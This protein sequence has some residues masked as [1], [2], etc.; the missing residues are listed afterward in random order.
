ME[1][2]QLRIFL[3]AA[4]KNSFSGAARSLYI[5]HSSVSRAIAALEAELGSTLIQRDGNV[6]IGLTDAGRVLKERAPLL[7]RMAE[8]AEEAV[9]RAG[10]G[11]KSE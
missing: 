8:E 9:R 10:N 4:D 5:S 11:E 3:A 2:S 7:L 1:L 6:V